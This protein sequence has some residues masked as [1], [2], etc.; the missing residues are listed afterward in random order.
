MR[1]FTVFSKNEPGELSS[2][3]D[4]LAKYAVGISSV[5]TE[6]TIENGPIKLVTEDAEAAARA[7]EE[8]GISFEVSDL[9]LV[10]VLNQPGELGRMAKTLGDA[11][12]N[13]EA[14]Y[15]LGNGRYAIRVNDMGHA[16]QVLNDRLL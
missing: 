1:E 13:I 8:A 6:G 15:R 16:K 12:I 11:D 9:L 3:F 14:I 4:A 7:L 2:I 5:V 10:R